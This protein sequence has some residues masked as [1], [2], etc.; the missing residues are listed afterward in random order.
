[1]EGKPLRNTL[2]PVLTL[3]AGLTA[4][5]VWPPRPAIAQPVVIDF[6]SLASMPNSA[7]SVVPLEARLSTQLITTNGVKFDSDAGYVAVVDLG[8][9]NTASGANGIGATAP[10]SVLTYAGSSPI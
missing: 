9:G 1:L 6:D 2:R 8:M 4:L 5:L 3:L 7:G 10:G